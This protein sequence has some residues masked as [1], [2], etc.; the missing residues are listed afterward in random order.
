MMMAIGAGMS[1]ILR[2]RIQKSGPD[3]RIRPLL[4]KAGVPALPFVSRRGEFVY[5]WQNQRDTSKSINSSAVLDLTFASDDS[6]LRWSE[7]QI[8]RAGKG[9]TMDYPVSVQT[10]KPS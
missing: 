7:C 9:S 4:G 5:E 3:Y 8:H 2:N 1:L 6:R 10:S